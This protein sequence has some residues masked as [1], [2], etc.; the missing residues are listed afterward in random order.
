VTYADHHGSGEFQFHIAP[1]LAMLMI[2]YYAIAAIF[3]RFQIFLSFI[4]LFRY[5]A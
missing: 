5:F 2:A 1:L 4:S 3:W